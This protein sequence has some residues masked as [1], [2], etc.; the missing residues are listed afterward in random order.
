[1]S[2]ETLE[3]LNTETLIGFTERRGKAWHFRADLQ[4][5]NGNHYE[6]A[7]PLEDARAFINRWRVVQGTLTAS[8]ITE[9]GVLT[10]DV[11]RLQALMRS[12]TGAVLGTPTTTYGLHQFEETVLNKVVDIVDDDLGIASVVFLQGG[13]QCAVQLEM[14]ESI[15][16]PGDFV[17]RPFITASGSHNST[18][19]TSYGT[20]EVAVVCDNTLHAARSSFDK[21]VRIK[22]TRHSL[23]RVNLLDL[24]TALGIVHGIADDFSKEL[25][26][27]LNEQVSNDRFGKWADQFA[28]TAAIDAMPEGRGKTLA[29]NKRDALWD[30][31]QK[32]ERV[33]P[34]KNT[35]L[36]VLQAG[37][38]WAH[39]IQ[40]VKGV[41]RDE[42]NMSRR[43]TGEFDKLDAQILA[44]LA[45]V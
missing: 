37:N 20:G 6:Q 17:F 33:T 23:E 26:E 13:A 35:A 11:P 30:L 39:H 31:W 40:T 27:L 9:D 22:H 12:D 21:E 3:W 29:L 42:R 5:G 15:T 1:M 10:G 8:A 16:G 34:W 28:G 2:R 19:P 14:P 25:D 43:L 41:S 32:D 18:L 7:I 36:G 24:R 44:T 38:T 45:A 4:T